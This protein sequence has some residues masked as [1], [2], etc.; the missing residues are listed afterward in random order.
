MLEIFG[1]CEVFVDSSASIISSPIR[2]LNWRL[3]PPGV[4]PWNN[5]QGE[6]QSIINLA[7]AGN[8]PVIEN[9]FRTIN[10]FRPSVVA[11]GQ[12]GFAGYVV[13]GFE[14]KQIFLLES[15]RVNNATY[16]FGRQW[17]QLSRLSKTE[18]LENTLQQDRI[19]HRSG[20][21]QHIA[22]LLN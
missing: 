21:H 13:F 12:A 8:R 6:M 4:R 18:I 5:L 22:R 9:R 11:I 20:W 14:E 10:G 17:E 7:P 16:V 1:E 2:R 19:I 3:L 15:I